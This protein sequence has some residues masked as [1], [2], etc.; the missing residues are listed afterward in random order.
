MSKKAPIA[1]KTGRIVAK[2]TLGTG[3]L[4]SRFIVALSKGIAEGTAET[5]TEFKAG[6]V[7]A[8]NEYKS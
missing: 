3:I 2:A 5:V 8:R 7:A 6:F 1:Q 4:A